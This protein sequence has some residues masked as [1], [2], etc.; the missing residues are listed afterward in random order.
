MER[1]ERN[2]YGKSGVRVTKVVRRG[3]VHEIYEFDVE[4]G[5]KGDFDR[6]YTEGDNSL[7]VPT[8]TMKNM[9]YV[10]ARQH[11]FS[12]PEEFCV[13]LGRHFVSKFPQVESAHVLIEQ[14]LWH[15]IDVDG[16]PH[17]H[18]FV[19]ASNARRKAR[20]Y[21]DRRDNLTLT[22]GVKDLEVVKSGNSAFEGFLRDEY[23]T[24][25]ETRD[26]IFGTSIEATW[27]YRPKDADV[28]AAYDAA[29]QA[30]LTTFATHESRGV[31]H[32]IYEMGRQVLAAVPSIHT[33]NFTLPNK[34]RILANLEPFGLT[35]ENEVFVNTS[36][37]YGE[38]YGEMTRVSE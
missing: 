36:E 1:L 14:T 16:K 32:T 13:L 9:V 29:V 24:L 23:T 3:A 10:I 25:K 17:D 12:S 7:C 5:L 30:I 26:R 8:D 34:H 22:G 27:Y 38:S 20:V 21:V 11:A 2:R 18:A 15:R 19:K 35:N 37:P 33:I 31:Q 6:V 28:N 4:I